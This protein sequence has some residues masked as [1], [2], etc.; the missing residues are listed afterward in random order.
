MKNNWQ[1]PQDR[2][3]ISNFDVLADQLQVILKGVLEE[4]PMALDNNATLKAKYFYH[5]CMNLSKSSVYHLRGRPYTSALAAW[6][7]L[8]GQNF[9]EKGFDGF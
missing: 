2:S 8:Y 5:S 1:E 4:G 9:R 6:W 3:S 7:H